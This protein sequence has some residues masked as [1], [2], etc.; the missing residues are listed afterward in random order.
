[1]LLIPVPYCGERPEIEFTYG[2]EAHLIRPA[3]PAATWMRNGP[4]SSICAPI[5]RALCRALAPR[6]RLRPFFNA[7]RDT[8]TDHFIV[9]LQVGTARPASQARH[10]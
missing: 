5:P 8:T 1:M 7:L 10:E 6:T 2:G 4:N 3:P 9:T